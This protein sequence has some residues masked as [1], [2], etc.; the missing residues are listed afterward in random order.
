MKTKVVS[1]FVVKKETVEEDPTTKVLKR[2]AIEVSRIYHSRDAAEVCL[3]LFREKNPGIDY[4]IH[5]KTKY[6]YAQIV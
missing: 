6:D 1:G 4:Y 5:E 3:K 2:Q